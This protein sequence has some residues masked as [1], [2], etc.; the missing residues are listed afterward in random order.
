MRTE[1]SESAAKVSNGLVKDY[2]ALLDVGSPA[3]RDK[4]STGNDL[5]HVAYLEDAEA[6]RRSRR[7]S[8]IQTLAAR[9]STKPDGLISQTV[10]LSSAVILYDARC[11]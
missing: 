8:S 10:S 3:R 2:V 1:L 7:C 6:E 9:S 11:Q 4:E 5:A